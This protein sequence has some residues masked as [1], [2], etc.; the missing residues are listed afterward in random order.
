MGDLYS[1]S[2][3]DMTKVWPPVPPATR[4][5]PTAEPGVGAWGGCGKQPPDTIGLSRE[6]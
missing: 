2:D 6:G 1:E 5:T 3:L 4:E